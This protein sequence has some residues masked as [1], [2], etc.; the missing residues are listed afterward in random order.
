MHETRFH[1][2]VIEE[3]SRTI[4]G[5]EFFSEGLHFSLVCV[6]DNVPGTIFDPLMTRAA[7]VDNNKGSLGPSMSLGEPFSETMDLY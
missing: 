2:L 5:E 1:V 3:S 7:F 6:T 4:S